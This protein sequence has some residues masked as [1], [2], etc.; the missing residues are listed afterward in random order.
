MSTH[1]DVEEAGARTGEKLDKDAA[2]F[3]ACH[4]RR[5]H[6]TQAEHARVCTIKGLGGINAGLTDPR[7][8]TAQRERCYLLGWPGRSTLTYGKPYNGC[9]W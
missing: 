4:G 5:T 9:E 7:F 1:L 8:S 2:G 3:A 6:A